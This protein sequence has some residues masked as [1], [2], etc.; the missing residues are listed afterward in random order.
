MHSVEYVRDLESDPLKC[1]TGDMCLVRPPRKANDGPARVGI[2]VR[3]SKTGSPSGVAKGTTRFGH[4]TRFDREHCYEVPCLGRI[5]VL[6]ALLTC[7]GWS[8]SQGKENTATMLGRYGPGMY[9]VKRS[10]IKGTPLFGHGTRF[11]REHCYEVPCLA[12]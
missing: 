7:G 11:D 10:T 8:C 4:G 5:S 6:L 1:G 12:A 2:P 9:D 3:C